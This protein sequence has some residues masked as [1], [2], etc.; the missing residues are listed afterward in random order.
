MKKVLDYFYDNILKPHV[1][2]EFDNE[3]A[4]L[5]QGAWEAGVNPDVN[6]GRQQKRV[7]TL[8]TMPADLAN[9]IRLVENDLELCSKIKL[10]VKRYA[11]GKKNTWVLVIPYTNGTWPKMQKTNPFLDIA[12]FLAAWGTRTG[13]A[14][15]INA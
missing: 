2:K 3:I 14:I 13:R 4:A 5:T 15:N 6:V 7:I 1:P 10:Y 9:I 12:I 11:N 8:A